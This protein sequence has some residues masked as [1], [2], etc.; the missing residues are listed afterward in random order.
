MATMLEAPAPAR[1]RRR[2]RGGG[3]RIGTAAPARVRQG[4]P[5]PFAVLDPW[6]SSQAGN[7]NRHAAA[8]RP[9]AREEFPAGAAAPSEGHL[10]AANRLITLLRSELLKANA[11]VRQAAEAARRSPTR[12]NLERLLVTKERSHQWV[13]SVERIW[14][15]Y[16]ELFGQRTD[17]YGEWLLGC[18]R[19]ALDCYQAAFR[20]IGA[21]KTVPAPPPFAYMKTGFSPATYRR[22]VPLSRLGR[23]P[24]P[25]PL[26]ELPFHRMVNPWTLGAVLHEVS[27]NLQNDLGLDSLIPREIERN[28]TAAGLGGEVART[29]RRWNRETFADMSGLLLGGP[30]VVASLMDVVGRSPR[31][32]LHFSPRAPHPT[33]YLRTLVST[34]LLRR[35]GFTEQSRR[36]E[37]SWRRLYSNPRAGSIPPAML[38]SFPHAVRVVVDTICFR[39]YRTLGGR[40]LATSYRF[41]PKDQQMIEDAARRLAAGVDPGVVP[42]RFLIGAARVALDRRYARPGTIAR[43]FYTELARR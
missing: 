31:A 25:F 7:S 37:R 40:S 5:P 2:F 27:H 10:Q 11:G 16:L 12:A 28:L 23:M 32:T 43:N 13:R 35:M 36:F 39:P 33:P 24:N 30:A 29:W 38:D 14:D 20:G 4:V 19:I 41:E 42:A 22:G 34:E 8:L 6:L 1:R 17:P 21:H 9:F 3:R 15:F 26:I 18:D